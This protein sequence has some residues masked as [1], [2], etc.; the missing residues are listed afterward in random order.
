MKRLDPHQQLKYLRLKCNSLS[1]LIYRDY[2]LYLQVVRNIL[3]STIRKVVFTIITEKGI[4]VFSNFSIDEREVLKIKIEK[5]ISRCCSLLTVEHLIDLSRKIDEEKKLL[6]EQAKDELIN[7]FKRDRNSHT[8]EE[9]SIEL[10]IRPPLNNISRLDGWTEYTEES[11]DGSVTLNPKEVYP[12]ESNLELISLEKN[13][14][15]D[16]EY[17]NDEFK[18]KEELTS[19]GIDFFK[20]LFLLAGR[21]FIPNKSRIRKTTN[22]AIDNED[23]LYKEESSDFNLL[24]DN[25]IELS[26]WIVSF[27]TALTRRLRNLSHA[28]N[29]ELMSYGI[30]NVLIPVNLLEAVLSGNI[31]TNNSTSNLITLNIPIHGSNDDESIEISCVLLRT[32]DLEFENPHLRKVRSL[33]KS[34]RQNL[35]TMVKQ[36]KHWQTRAIT[37]ELHQSWWTANQKSLSKNVSGADD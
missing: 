3:K 22:Q 8:Y 17:L 13:E 16:K 29:M 18:G 2:A 14:E 11:I 36:Q 27:D 10:N 23:S 7:M 12:D 31:Q 19:N 1:P 21:S 20:D 6:Q 34:H 32:S 24:P 30:V 35:F 9:G 26:S 5:L 15:D 37:A 33:I 28:I 25:P 4:D